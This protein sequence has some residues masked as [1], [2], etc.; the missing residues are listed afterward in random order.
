MAGLMF[1]S[2]GLY[3]KRDISQGALE[4]GRSCDHLYF[5]GYTSFY[6]TSVEELSSI[7]GKNVKLLSRDWL[8]DRF[9]SILSEASKATVGLLIVGDCF[10]AT[11]HTFLLKEAKERNIPVRVA[12]G[13]SILGAVGETGLFLYNF[14]KITSIPFKQDGIITP[15]EVLG[16]NLSSGLHTL[17][18][19]DLDTSSSKYLSFS[20]ALSYLFLCEQTLKKGYISKETKVVVCCALGSE[21]SKIYFGTIDQLS[22]LPLQSSPQSVIVPSTTL[23]FMEEEVLSLYKVGE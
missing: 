11:T 10:F 21:H 2:L 23:H 5:E 1:I 8:E 4:L 17:F 6:E 20:E 7:F 14:G 15:Y 9:E 18:L 13:S 19:L 12:H 22:S 3:S 16:S